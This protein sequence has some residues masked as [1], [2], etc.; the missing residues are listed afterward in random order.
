MNLIRLE[1]FRLIGDAREQERHQRHAQLLRQFAVQA[2]ELLGVVRAVIGRYIH[3]HQHNLCV[4]LLSL[5]DD[6][7]QVVLG[8]G[9]RHAAQRIVSAELDDH[10]ARL[11]TLH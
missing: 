10:D 2:M 4:T 11:Q 8:G 1:H 5:L 9:E 6:R 3:A 7:T